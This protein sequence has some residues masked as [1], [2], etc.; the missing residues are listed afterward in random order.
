VKTS[1][2]TTL[3]NIIVPGKRVR[4]SPFI[5][6]AQ[7]EVLFNE[8]PDFMEFRSSIASILDRNPDK[9]RTLAQINIDFR[10]TESRD[11]TRQDYGESFVEGYLAYYFSTNVCK[12]QVILLELLRSGNMPSRLNVVDIGLGSGTTFVALID[13]LV[14]WA[15]VCELHGERFPV[16]ALELIGYDKSADAIEITSKLLDRLAHHLTNNTISPTVSKLIQSAVSKKTLIKQ[17][18]EQSVPDLTNASVVVASNVI[19][20][21]REEATKPALVERLS[22]LSDGALCILV[23]AGSQVRSHA[24]N[25]FKRSL[26]NGAGLVPVIPCGMEFGG[27]QPNQCDKCWNSRRESFH[28][29]EL[30]SRLLTLFRE[31]E[32]GDDRSR[33]KREFDNR[34]LSWT[35][36]VLQKST[37]APNSASTG[38]RYIGAFHQ[39]ALNNNRDDSTKESNGWEPATETVTIHTGSSRR[40][41]RYLKFCPALLSQPT[42]A[43]VMISDPETRIDELRHGECVDIPAHQLRIDEQKKTTFIEPAI[44]HDFRVESLIPPK[45]EGEVLVD[46]PYSQLQRRAID[47]LCFRLFGFSAMRDFQHMVLERVLRGQSVLGITA[48]GGGKSECFILPAMLTS[49]ITIVISPLKSLMKD[50]YEQRI[51]KRYGLGNVSTFINSDIDFR[52]RYLRLRRIEQGYY[53]LVYFTPEQLTRSHVLDAIENADKN[54]GIRYLAVDEAH[55]ISQWGHDFRPAYLN[56]LKRLRDRNLN[57]TRIALT[58]TASPQVREEVCQELALD[59]VSDVILHQS[60]RPE[61]NLVVATFD[62]SEA[63]GERIASLLAPFLSTPSCQGSAICFQP[64]GQGLG[65]KPTTNYSSAFYVSNLGVDRFAQHLEERFGCRVSVHYSKLDDKDNK[66]HGKLKEIRSRNRSAEQEMF[67]EGKTKVMVATKGFGMGIDKPDIRT[68][69]HRTPPSSIEAY[70]QEAG[71]AGRDGQ[72]S[73]VVLCFSGDKPSYTITKDGSDWS[74]KWKLRGDLEI[75]ASFFKENY[76]RAVDVRRVCEYLS[77]KKANPQGRFIIN[78]F[79]MV[80]FFDGRDFSWPSHVDSDNEDK[81]AEALFRRKSKYLDKIF[82]VIVRVRPLIDGDQ[83]SL[84]DAKSSHLRPYLRITSPN[85]TSIYES[86]H[87]FGEVIR[88]A[89]PEQ[90]QFEA[91]LSNIIRQDD[92]TPL[93]NAL[94]TSLQEACHILRDMRELNLVNVVFDREFYGTVNGARLTKEAARDLVHGAAVTHGRSRADIPG[95]KVWELTPGAAF[96]QSPLRDQYISAFEK[97][98][99]RRERY[100]RSAYNR[101]VQDYLGI[102]PATGTKLDT[103]MR[104]LRATILGYLETGETVVGDDCGSCSQCRPDLNFVTDDVLRANAVQ[105]LSASLTSLLSKFKSHARDLVPLADVKVFWSEVESYDSQAHVTDT[106]VGWIGKQLDDDGDHVGAIILQLTGILA[107]CL[108]DKPGNL[109]EWT[110]Q[111]LELDLSDC[112]EYLIRVFAEFASQTDTWPEHHMALANVHR[113]DNSAGRN[114]IQSLKQCLDFCSDT[115]LELANEAHQRLYDIYCPG[116]QNETET[117]CLEHVNGLLKLNPGLSSVVDLLTPFAV[118]WSLERFIEEFVEM[119]TLH[120]WLKDD[121]FVNAVIWVISQQANVDEANRSVMGQIESGRNWWCELKGGSQDIF[122]LSVALG[123][124]VSGGEL[125]WRKLLLDIENSKFK[126]H[127]DNIEILVN[128]LDA[129][130]ALRGALLGQFLTNKGFGG[131]I[132]NLSAIQSKGLF[133]YISAVTPDST[134]ELN[135]LLDGLSRLAAKHVDFVDG[136]VDQLEKW[137][138]ASSFEITGRPS[139][140]LFSALEFSSDTLERVF[141]LYIRFPLFLGSLPNELMEPPAFLPFANDN[142]KQIGEQSQHWIMEHKSFIALSGYEHLRGEK[143]R[144][145]LR[146]G[147]GPQ[148]E[149]EATTI[150]LAVVGGMTVSDRLLEKL[151]K[152]RQNEKDVVNTSASKLSSKDKR[153][154][155]EIVSRRTPAMF[156]ALEAFFYTLT[157]LAMDNAL[158][159]EQAIEFLRINLADL[160]ADQPVYNYRRLDIKPALHNLQVVEGGLLDELL[161][162]LIDHENVLGDIKWPP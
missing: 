136:V 64:Y 100:Q 121:V 156:P 88:D 99:D 57:P 144:S 148:T 126:Y 38:F 140:M 66:G 92:V 94:N 117:E 101:L 102:D 91:V 51:K 18:I 86:S 114:E 115:V 12:I 61:L 69:V 142:W 141:Q 48:T 79:D 149:V 24:L 124:F 120:P 116:P 52:E 98:Q 147:K 43:L 30:F 63:R 67:I 108:G 65:G 11:F 40:F 104:C 153:V 46:E 111:M 33:K 39:D 58:A 154:L 62:S 22:Q 15:H 131:C 19:N 137:L 158:L 42:A 132:D 139:R 143:C 162:I 59:P 23:E 105:K 83:M 20:E 106:I 135:V 13:F 125:R 56:L 29:T 129:G 32:T 3:E 113:E 45:S 53:K 89:M 161:A 74:E 34:L 128:D 138:S 146:N 145:D 70:V 28:E 60:N 96:D 35:Y 8:S 6:A 110:N 155:F 73:T 81:R 37:S 26:T 109:L 103:E 119:K 151:L 130:L 95:P 10:A 31:S 16:E 27:E 80:S 76:V 160:N 84:L 107:N 71:R 133:D 5:E 9:I 112:P 150:L 44:R 77:S 41:K 127:S 7:M 54:V 17:D 50:Q 90:T 152:P 118:H 2:V 97:D 82:E 87:Y 47:H 36:V 93:A 14:L 21:L 75:Q 78:D 134:E 49:G 25:R 72:Y 123:S 85:I 157:T 1:V 68:V 159:T 122:L 4:L 55:C